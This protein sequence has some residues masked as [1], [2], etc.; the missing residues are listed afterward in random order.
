MKALQLAQTGEWDKA[1][2]ESEASLAL[3]A[4][5]PGVYFLQSQIFL[6]ENKNKEALVKI[7]KASE[8]APT[9]NLIKSQVTF[10]EAIEIQQEVGDMPAALA[11]FKQSVAEMKDEF[12]AKSLEKGAIAIAA[13]GDI[14]TAMNVLKTLWKD[15][16]F[17]AFQ[18]QREMHPCIAD[19]QS[20]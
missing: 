19:L 1:Y 9:N 15:A 6:V 12:D 4:T 11:K 10:H 16:P 18:G 13:L 5:Q 3:N 2:A 20:I 8:L 7:R 17:F 14:P